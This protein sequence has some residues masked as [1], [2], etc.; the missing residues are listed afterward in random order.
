MIYLYML[1]FSLLFTVK[2]EKTG[3]CMYDE[4]LF[5]QNVKNIG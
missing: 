3:V 1:F 5:L 2:N 4:Q